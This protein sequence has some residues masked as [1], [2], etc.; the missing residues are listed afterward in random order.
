VIYVRLTEERIFGLELPSDWEERR[1]DVCLY[2]DETTICFV[3]RSMAGYVPVFVADGNEPIYEA[4]YNPE[5][6]KW[7]CAEANKAELGLGEGD[8]DEIVG[9]SMQLPAVGGT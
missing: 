3:D 8:A 9:S 4:T 2:A 5:E 7:L 6:A 1:G